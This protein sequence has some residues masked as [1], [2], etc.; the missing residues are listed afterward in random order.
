MPPVIAAFTRA[1]ACPL[2]SQKQ[3]ADAASAAETRSRGKRRQWSVPIG[4]EDAGM[5]E[6]ASEHSG[7]D[8]EDDNVSAE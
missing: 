7:T 8:A 3:Q 4:R 6:N 1:C 5:R 2:Q